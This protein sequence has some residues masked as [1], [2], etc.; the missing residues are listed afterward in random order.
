MVNSPIFVANW[1]SYLSNNSA[2]NWIHTHR[3]RLVQIALKNS[4]IICPDATC[5]AYAIEKLSPAVHI[6]GQNCSEYQPGAHTGEIS[7]QSLKE[8]GAQFCII[9]HSETRKAN[10]ETADC[11]A[12]K[13]LRLQDAGITPIICIGENYQNDLLTILPTLK[14]TTQPLSSCFFAF[15]PESAIGTNILL[16]EQSLKESLATIKSLINTTLFDTKTALLYGGSVSS[17]TIQ[18]LK[19]ISEIDGFLLGRASLDF[20]ELENIVICSQRC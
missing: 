3:E 20:Q 9:G 4:I 17:T 5:L 19:K 8:V 18:S 14:K 6:G 7:A 13:A 1:K 2:K 10:S 12:Q 16:P 11:I 15:E